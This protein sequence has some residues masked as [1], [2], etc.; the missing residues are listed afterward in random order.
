MLTL[1]PAA[2]AAT[3]TN[4]GYRV[5]GA[6]SGPGSSHKEYSATLD[7]GKQAGTTLRRI[8]GLCVFV[9]PLIF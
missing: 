3:A 5:K 8:S 1:F 6:V 4:E 7:P 2:A 9:F